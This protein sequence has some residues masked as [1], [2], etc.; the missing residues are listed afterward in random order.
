M[1]LSVLGF[2]GNA[3]EGSVAIFDADSAPVLAF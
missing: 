3:G 2:N 1:Q